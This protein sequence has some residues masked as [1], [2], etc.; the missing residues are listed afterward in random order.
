MQTNANNEF[1]VKRV[2]FR[3]H[4]NL[5]FVVIPKNSTIQPGDYVKIQKLEAQ[6]A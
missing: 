6:S 2:L 5:K 3:K 1:E 4:D